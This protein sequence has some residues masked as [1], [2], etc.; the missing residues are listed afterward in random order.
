MVI[1]MLAQ[2]SSCVKKA[3]IEK[4]NDD[5]PDVRVKTTR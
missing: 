1:F 2:R 3:I 4:K 5:K